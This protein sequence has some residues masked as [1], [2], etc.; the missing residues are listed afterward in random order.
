MKLMLA[1]VTATVA[2]AVA[3]QTAAAEI[4]TGL[5]GETLVAFE[6]PVL[7][8]SSEV[9]GTCNPTTVSTFSFHTAGVAVGPYPGTFDESGTFSIGPAPTFGLLSFEST[10]TIDGADATVSGTKTLAAGGAVFGFC[11][12]LTVGGGI[13]ADDVEARANLDYTAQI[14]TATGTSTDSGTSHV[15]YGD[16]RV[17]GLPGLQGFSFIETYVSTA[18]FTTPG[19]STGGGQLQS[20]VTFGYVAIGDEN[21]NGPKGTCNVVDDVSSTHVKCLD[22]T[23][24]MQT[25]THVTFTGNATV[26]GAPTTYR[27]DVDDVSEPNLG[28]DTF[29]IQTGSGYTAGGQVTSG[30]VQVH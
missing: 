24:Y 12:P 9:T 30:N 22:V 16:T 7:V 19:R 6:T 20:G 27:I 13:S 17:R 29:A 3:A 14:T 23:T 18:F 28:Q 1:V 5:T 11:G 10:F 26:D 25:G 21:G 2:A 8:G 15:E 4:T